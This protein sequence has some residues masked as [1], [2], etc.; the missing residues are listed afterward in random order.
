MALEA[1]DTQ[2]VGAVGDL[3]EHQG[4]AVLVAAGSV[5]GHIDLASFGLMSNVVHLH[6]STS[7]IEQIEAEVYET[8]DRMCLRVGE[9]LWEAK[10]LN[11]G[12]F[13]AWVDDR[14]PFG[15]DKARRLIA[16]FVAYRELP[17]EKLAQLP[18]PWQA[19]YALAPYAQGRLIEA[20]ESG[21]IG[22]DTTVREA[23]ASAR[24][25]GSNQRKVDPLTARYTAADN[26]AGALME[27]RPDDLNP[28]VLEALKRWL[29]RSTPAS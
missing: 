11:P 15:H 3:E 17:A 10:S 27:H 21:E 8:V 25:W 24:H 20:L 28:Y 7:R 18:R 29:S 26:R 22:P 19:M 13:N 6:E 23:A 14:M 1:G 5:S 9:L 12:G 4:A 2:A 16:I